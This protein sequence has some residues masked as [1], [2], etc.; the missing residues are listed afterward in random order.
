MRIHKDHSGQSIIEF[1]L[2]IP[3]ILAIVLAFTDLGRV[4]YF[5]SAVNNAVREAA[6]FGTVTQFASEEDRD[7]EIKQKVEQFS[8]STPLNLS[9]ITLYCDLDESV[10]KFPCDNYITVTATISIEPIVP[11][12]SKVIGFGSDYTITA[13][14]TMLMTPYG[15]YHE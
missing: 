7:Q 3:I 6:R 10:P 1:A 5:Y 13:E 9:D 4:V 8:I 14:S 2:V 11:L 12:I 15:K